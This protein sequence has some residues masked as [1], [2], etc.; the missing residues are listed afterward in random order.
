ML[1]KSSLLAMKE[2]VSSIRREGAEYLKQKKDEQENNLGDIEF[3][4][5]QYSKMLADIEV[6]PEQFRRGA[7]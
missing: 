5:A 7:L 4:E 6:M 2:E 3:L 1:S